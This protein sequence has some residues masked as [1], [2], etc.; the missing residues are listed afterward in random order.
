MI[1]LYALYKALLWR[2]Q[3]FRYRLEIEQN[4]TDLSISVTEPSSEK[5]FLFQTDL[6]LFST[7]NVGAISRNTQQVHKTKAEQLTVLHLTQ[8]SI[9]KRSSDCLS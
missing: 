3:L 5:A 1:Q 8:V 9:A 4:V 2:A 6:P 7:P